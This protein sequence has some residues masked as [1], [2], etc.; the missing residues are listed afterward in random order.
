MEPTSLRQSLYVIASSPTTFFE[1]LKRII[2]HIHDRLTMDHCRRGHRNG[3]QTR[4]TDYLCSTSNDVRLE[5]TVFA[6]RRRGGDGELGQY[7][8]FERF[9]QDQRSH[10]HN[11]FGREAAMGDL[12]SGFEAISEPITVVKQEALELIDFTMP[13]IIQPVPHRHDKMSAT[14]LLT[15]TADQLQ[16]SHTVNPI[17]LTCTT[18]MS[19]QNLPTGHLA[20]AGSPIYS[21]TADTT[22]ERTIKKRKPPAP[23]YSP[24]TTTVSRKSYDGQERPPGTFVCD[25]CH[26]GFARSDNFT[27][28]KRTHEGFVDWICPVPMCL[29]RCSRASNGGEHLAKVHQLEGRCPQCQQDFRRPDLVRHLSNKESPCHPSRWPSSAPGHFQHPSTSK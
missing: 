24:R 12:A 9:D 28:H 10:Q 18:S 14:E 7:F 2:S 23:R 25:Q 26:K 19:L 27:R 15:E 13:N 29:K 22:T 1:D 16:F 8:D 20:S 11:N 21:P 3:T 17:T 5:S 6:S 4:I